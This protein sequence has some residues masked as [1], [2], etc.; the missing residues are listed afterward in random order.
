MGKT[1]IAPWTDAQVAMLDDR[2]ARDDLHPYTCG[3]CSESLTPYSS[4][5]RCDYC[6]Q[7][8]QNWCHSADVE[9]KPPAPGPGGEGG[10]V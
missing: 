5:W 8:S 9:A 7:H 2:Q 1:T 3:V 4:G 10:T 6:H